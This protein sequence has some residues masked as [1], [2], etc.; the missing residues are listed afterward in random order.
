MR[1]LTILLVIFTVGC[2]DSVTP[3]ESSTYT[4]EI[5]SRLDKTDDGYYVLPIN[6]GSFQTLHR[7][8]GTLT[9]DGEIPDHREKIGWESSHTWVLGDTLGYI[10]RR[11]INSDGNWAV[12]DTSYV[13]GFD[14]YEV[15]TINSTSIT[16]ENGDFNVMMAPIQPMRGDTLTVRSFIY[17]NGTEF[18]DIINVILK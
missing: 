6:D 5:D 4:V 17:K 12:L 16:K 3:L 13:T 8:S 15:P 7:L 10:I 9:Q 14:G 11:T 18:D 1:L 2:S